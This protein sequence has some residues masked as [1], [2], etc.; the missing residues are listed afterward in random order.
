MAGAWQN[1]GRKSPNQAK[2]AAY[3]TLG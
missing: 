2:L 1:M 3:L